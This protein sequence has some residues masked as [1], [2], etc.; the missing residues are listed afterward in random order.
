MRTLHNLKL[1]KKILLFPVLFIIVV[2]VIFL[3]TQ[4]SNNIS[5][6]E[7]D[8]IQNGH[9]PFIEI[10][11]E[12]IST[13][14]GLQKAFQDGV[15]AQD[16]DKINQT[17][18]L[19]EQFRTLADSA[20]KI[21]DLRNQVKIDSTMILFNEYYEVAV[22]TSK[23]MIAEE[24]SEEVSMNM[25]RMISKLT[26]L[27]DLLS[28]ISSN[29][30]HDMS[31]AFEKT[32]KQSKKLAIIIQVVLFLSLI[33]FITISL[34]LSRLIVNALKATTNNLL[35]LSQGQ[36]N[37]KVP[38]NYLKGKDEIGDIS[39]AILNL[40]KKLTEVIKG[41]QSEVV[42]IS[43]ISTNL[44]RTSEIIAE[45][46]NEQA[47]SVEEVSSTM[48]EIVANIDQTTEYSVK[49]E[50]IAVSSANDMTQVSKAAEESLESVTSITDKINMISDI[51]FQTN[52]LALNAAVEAARAG[53]HGR[54]FSVVASEV[55]KLAE[56][57]KFAADEIT[58]LAQVSLDNTRNSERLTSKTIPEIKKTSLWIQ[59]ISA[60]SIEQKNGVEQ[61]N[62]SVQ[63][64]SQIA[65]QNATASEQMAL[66]SDGLINQAK[67]LSL[68]VSYF[69][70]E[71]SEN[72]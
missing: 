67:K 25:Q 48:E 11:N 58:R 59:E 70:T 13:Q 68:L 20:K 5:K 60:A 12:L 39:R 35:L 31:M 6:R 28:T 43:N 57:S 9:I 54:G 26:V 53:E 15:A 10:S 47:A 44:N 65:Q 19:A 61:V 33:T 16:L 8:S 3:V 2:A 27:K 49:T 4:R 34:F 18:D 46:S 56:K 22:T 24:Y 14:T 72:N 51:A 41:V 29:A 30:K 55:R 40:V 69:K 36:L 42:E 66:T 64:L 62:Q 52:I 17:I 45:G 71:N 32:E 63:Q 7:L 23:S 50:K 38:E 37:I 21:T 1:K